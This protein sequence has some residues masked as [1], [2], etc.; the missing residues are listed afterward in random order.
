MSIPKHISEFLDSQGVWYQHFTHSLAYT[1]QGIAHAQHISGKHLAKV[2][3]VMADGSLIMAVV[4]G[5]HRVDLLRLGEILNADSI[6]LAAE[7]E[8][9]DIFPD[10]DLGAMPPLGNLYKLDVWMDA[11]L[12]SHP[13]ILFNAGTHSETILMSI[14]DFDRMV[15]PKIGAF[16][17]LMH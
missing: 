8:F 10:C 14:A 6:R 11:S 3:M 12:K 1:A 13:H 17:V 5:N 7:D 9:K 16:S 4:P 15:Q 2:V